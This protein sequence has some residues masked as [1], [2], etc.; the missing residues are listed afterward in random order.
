MKL[1]SI[2]AI[3]VTLLSNNLFAQTAADLKTWDTNEYLKSKVLAPINADYAY[4]RG[5]TGKGSS[6]AILD[7]G[8]DTTSKEFAGRI[9]LTKDFTGTVITDTYGHGT[10]VAGVAAAGRDNINTNNYNVQG[11]AFDATLM[12]GK[13]TP[14]SGV[15]ET[16]ILQG[17]NWASSNGA[18]AINIS[19]FDVPISTVKQLSPGVYSTTA[20]NTGKIPAGLN[21]NQ[22]A[23]ALTGQSVLVL[24]AGNG[25]AK[26]PGAEGALATATDANGN[27]LLGGKVIIAGNYNP[28]TKTIDPTSNQAGSL[29]AVAVANVCQDKY[30]IS[31][32]YLMAP[33]GV[34]SVTQANSTV[35]PTGVANMTG[36]S[37]AAPA[38]A[39]AVA[40]IHQQWPQMTGANIAKL[41]LMT[42]NKNI[43]GYDP[44]VM[45]Q[46]VLNLDAA[47]KPIGTLGI[48]TTGG[49][50]ATASTMPITPLVI[51]SGNISISGKSSSVMVVD[52]FQRDYYI[53]TKALT[54]VAPN[55][56]FNIN[57][58][59]MPYVSK[60]NYSQ[61][62]NFTDYKNAAFGDVEMS[63]Y[64]D[65]NY[66]PTGN[67][68]PSMM[69][70]GYNKVY[71]TTK[72]KL[73]AG[74]LI[75]NGTWLGN[76]TP[77]AGLGNNTVQSYTTFTGVQLDQQVT[78]TTNV[79]AT[80]KHGITNTTGINSVM[81]NNV[82]PIMS[83]TWSMGIDQ[84]VTD[85]HTV[86]MMV[87]QPVTVY[88]AMA[89]SNMPVGLDSNLNVISAGTINLAA[90]V[91]EYRAGLYH[92]FTNKDASTSVM[93]FIE[94]RQNYRGQPGITDN[95][96][97]MLASVRF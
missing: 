87:Y 42:G 9:V 90:D 48:P 77:T 6:I 62:N 40:I 35:T 61:F 29:C 69:E 41:L 25:G 37:F 60:N 49:S 65:K 19:S 68:N 23:T 58:A 21:A 84:K 26:T 12:I 88:R 54:V 27:L 55:P 72:V 63:V 43:T 31:D 80:V 18:T 44:N 2:L 38:I 32:F 39:G 71:G 59:A 8:I 34:V 30:K 4:A 36:T 3:S 64:L 53:P 33:G 11:V 45:G 7:S 15:G 75:E 1:K 92:R 24:A 22:W 94:N 57:Q 93:T 16:T 78:N 95:V 17:V 97:G 74:G 10:G 51:S 83:Y 85:N 14:S 89:N 96:V 81:I 52:S 66:N 70:I 79:Y 67:L 86:G 82:G 5:Y 28:A 47:T 20:T 50:V 46:G 73:T 76:S 13:V 91:K 56:T